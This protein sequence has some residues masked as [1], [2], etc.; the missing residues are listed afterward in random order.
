MT[1]EPRAY[2]RRPDPETSWEAANSVAGIRE[3]QWLIW[4]MLRHSGPKTDQQL[5]PLVME[6]H[7]E[8]FQKPISK[9]GCRTRRSELVTLGLV[10]HTGDFAKTEGGRPT[11]IWRALS[12]DE[13]RASLNGNAVQAELGL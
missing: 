8:Y 12:L 5:F 9:S 6:Y 10:E 13:Y 7:M 2:A 11:R 1:D 4:K 3:S